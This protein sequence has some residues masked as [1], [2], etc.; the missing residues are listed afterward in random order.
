MSG[1]IFFG[2]F[3]SLWLMGFGGRSFV[4]LVVR[5]SSGRSLWLRT[6]SED[7]RMGCTS[8]PSTLGERALGGRRRL[9]FG[10]HVRRENYGSA[11]GRS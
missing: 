7:E 5:M 4:A 2:V 8:A 11:G 9:L 1:S 3:Q 6:L 10:A